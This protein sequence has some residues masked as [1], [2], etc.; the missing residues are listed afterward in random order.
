M[1]IDDSTTHSSNNPNN[2]P[3]F[4]TL[5]NDVLINVY[6]FWP[7]QMARASGVYIYDTNDREYLDFGA[8]IA[9]TSLGYD[10]PGYNETLNAQIKKQHLGLCYIATEERLSAAQTLLSHSD[11]DQIFFCSTGAE[12]VEGCLKTARKRSVEVKGPEA[13][14]II[15]VKDSFHGRTMGALSVN[16]QE[17]LRAGFEPLLPG[18]YQAIFNDLDSVRNVI[19]KN[20]AAIIVEPVLGEGGI[21]AADPEFLQGLRD[22]CDEYNAVLIFDEV[23]CGMG[24]IGT[25]FA[26]QHY[27]VVPD[28]IALAKGLGGGFPVGAYMG[29]RDITA[30]IT[31]GSH[32]STYGGGPLACKIA[33]FM[34]EEIS[35]PDLLQNVRD[36]GQYLLDEMTAL[37]KETGAFSN[38]RGI[39]M[40]VAADYEKGKAKDLMHH[41]VQNGLI[42]LYCG[43]NSLRF[44]PPLI[45]TRD[46]VDEAMAKLRKTLKGGK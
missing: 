21:I 22:L 11:F 18:T 32:G 45:I 35:K 14:E 44:L 46:H 26:Y 25:L 20:T 28:L 3:E 17:D 34:V 10:Y 24:R 42:V 4:L 27:G 19:N 29:R 37:A 9:T 6:P 15:Y 33:Q 12:A 5:A 36:V 1:T 41:C 43:Q 23:Q 31:H 13:I 7:V 38:V 39:G 8:C 30:H 40:M 2:D 16:G